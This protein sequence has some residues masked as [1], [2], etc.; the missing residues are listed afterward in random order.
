MIHEAT[1]GVPRK[2]NLICDRL[3]LSAFLEE[4]HTI[5]LDVVC[6]VVQG[7]SEEG[8]AFAS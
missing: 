3:L 2:I 6:D 1:G 4:G 5:D 7:M 8:L